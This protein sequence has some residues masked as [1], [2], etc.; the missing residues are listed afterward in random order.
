MEVPTGTEIVAVTGATGYIAMHVVQQLLAAGYSVH[1]TVRDP[2]SVAKVK[3]LTDLA[4][5]LN[6]SDRLKLFKTDLLDEGSFDEAVKHADYVLHTASP[7]IVQ[8]SNPQRD[9]IDPAVNGTVNVL[10]AAN[11]SEKVKRVVL[12]SSVAAVLGN[13][14]DKPNHVYNEDD[15]N[16]SSNIQNSPYQFSKRLAEEKAWE[17]VKVQ[18]KYDLVTINPSL[19][20]G[21]TLSS[22]MCTSLDIFKKLAGGLMRAGAPE[23]VFALVDVRD[24]AAAHIVAIKHPNAKGRYLVAPEV[25]NVVE[26]GKVITNK[27]P[28]VPVPRFCLPKPM[29][30]L[31]G[32]VVGINWA[33]VKHNVGVPLRI[34]CDKIKNELG[35][36]FRS[37]SE[38]LPDML[39]SMVKFG[40]LRDYRG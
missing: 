24:V 27:Y 11:K 26:M 37:M 15:W 10:N 20:V 22:N 39:D 25:M 33:F 17:M 9:L 7:F 28:R 2:S 4:A 18:S 3:P 12:T 16:M 19:V 6:A 36:K 35:F 30:Y 32:P 38:S 21:P 29:V 34:S 13:H 5:S 1:A 40:L 23:L 8:V 31:I 14:D